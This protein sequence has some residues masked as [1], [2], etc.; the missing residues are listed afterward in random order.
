MFSIWGLGFGV[1]GSG[2]GVEDSGS[3]VESLRRRD[4][5][6][7]SRVQM[8]EFSAECCAAIQ[9]FL[10]AAQMHLLNTLVRILVR[11]A[12]PHVKPAAIPVNLKSLM[13]ERKLSCYLE[14]GDSYSHGARPVD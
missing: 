4:Q 13:L 14:N 1:Q 6:L 3:R 5:G 10:P 9:G 11:L 7:G 8:Q 12:A 2:F